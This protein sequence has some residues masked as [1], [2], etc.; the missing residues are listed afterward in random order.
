MPV[1]ATTPINIDDPINRQ[2]LSVSEDRVGGFHEQPFRFIAD[3]SGVDLE[4][5]LKR[6]AAMLEGGTIRRVR[7]TLLANKLA[8]GAL[9][10]WVV[11]N[12]KLN[13]TFDWLHANDPFS[14]HVVI[15]TTDSA[16]AGSQYRLWTTLKV[17]QGYAM[18]RH[19]E[20]LCS[21]TAAEQFLL[22]PAKKLFALGVGHV[23]RRTMEPG[24]RSDEP[25]K[26]IDTD[27]V[28]LSD[29]DWQVIYT[30]KRE[31][32]PHE[33]AADPWQAR[34]KEAGVSYDTF[35]DTA[36]SLDERS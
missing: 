25:G 13:E 24:A 18:E 29:L 6:I 14:G 12:E 20:Q 30:L 22:M 4:T 17:P 16:T 36:K 33:I 21:M 32:E 3:E 23:R 15:R 26:V 1:D 9:V 11:S 19:C 7:Q 2:I 8:P 10:A 27:V 28:P 34:A 31:F 35:I 5:T